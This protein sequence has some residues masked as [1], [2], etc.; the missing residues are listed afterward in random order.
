MGVLGDRCSWRRS[1]IQVDLKQVQN[2]DSKPAIIK[3]VRLAIS[4]DPRWTTL[5]Q[6]PERA[7]SIARLKELE[8]QLAKIPTVPLPVMVSSS[9]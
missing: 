3:R 4:D 6:D 8:R 9:L 5:R 1:R 7:Q 2:V